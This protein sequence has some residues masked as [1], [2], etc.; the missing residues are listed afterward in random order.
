MKESLQDVVSTAA[1]TSF[2]IKMSRLIG[3]YDSRNITS[4]SCGYNKKQKD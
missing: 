1:N 2:D 3:I 4:G